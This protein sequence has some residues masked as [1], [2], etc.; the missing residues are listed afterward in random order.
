ML[1]SRVPP[2]FAGR[3]LLEYLAQRFR[4][5][6]EAA[7]RAFIETRRV[8][9]DGRAARPSQLLARGTLVS[10][11]PPAAEPEIPRELPVVH[12]EAS[13]LVVEKPAGLVCHADGAFQQNTFLRELERQL[14]AREQHEVELRLAHRLDRETSGL[15]VV[16]R[17]A[18]AA[19][20]F[21]RQ[22]TGGLVEKRYLAIVRGAPAQERFEVDLPIGFSARSEIAI[23][24]EAS[25]DA[26]DARDSRTTFEV[27]ERHDDRSLVLC[28]PHTG[29][30]HQIRVHLEAAG[31]PVVGDKLYGVPDERYLAWVHAVKAGAPFEVVASFGAEHQLLHAAEIAFA[32]PLSG[33]ALRFAAR[34]PERFAPFAAR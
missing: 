5:H 18:E 31:H 8:T 24:R 10:F 6:D 12:E 16:A 21:E 11:E 32:H 33:E 28:T 26:R 15:L 14:S 25:S 17:S 34:W 3:S 27:L 1:S 19:R 9:V 7:W 23:R 13:F 29:R 22:F 2:A 20:S 4:Y 30:T